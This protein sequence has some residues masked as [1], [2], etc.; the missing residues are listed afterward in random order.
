[1]SSWVQLLLA[2]LATCLRF[3]AAEGDPLPAALVELV[4]NSPISSIEDLQLLL[5]SDSVDEEDG[6]FAANGGHRLPRSLGKISPSPFLISFKRPFCCTKYVKLLSVMTK[7]LTA[8]SSLDLDK[9]NL[10][11][12]SLNMCAFKPINSLLE[13]CSADVEDS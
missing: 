8:I 2:L 13:G 6:T 11:V 4:R 5:L 9:H 12:L 7:I 1:M 10:M 3:G